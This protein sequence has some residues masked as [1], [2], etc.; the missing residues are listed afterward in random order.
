MEVGYEDTVAR[1][2]EIR[3]FL[4]GVTCIAPPSRLSGT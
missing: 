2:D 1:A 3:A 4:A